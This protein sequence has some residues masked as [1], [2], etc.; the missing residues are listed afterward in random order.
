MTFV[1]Q[2]VSLVL[3]L[4]WL[5]LLGRAL[6]SFVFA[7]A[8]EWRPKGFVL[9]LVEAVFTAT[10]WLIKP[11]RRVVPPLTL[12]QMRFDLAFIIAFFTVYLLQIAVQALAA[13]LG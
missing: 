3:L 5:A 9:V 2:L 8:R 11:I 7:F 12:G 13:S 1:L 10:D 4:L 6:L